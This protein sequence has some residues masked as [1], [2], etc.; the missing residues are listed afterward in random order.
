MCAFYES[1]VSN[2]TWHDVYI[3]ELKQVTF[4]TTRTAWVKLGLW[5]VKNVNFTSGRRPCCQKRHLLKLT[6]VLFFSLFSHNAI[7]SNVAPFSLY[8]VS[9]KVCMQVWTSRNSKFPSLGVV[10]CHREVWVLHGQKRWPC[11]TAC[12]TG[13]NNIML[14]Y[15]LQLTTLNNIIHLEWGATML[16]NIVNIREQ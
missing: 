9:L 5:L 7:T 14:T 11:C 6:I 13:C 16:N 8:L 1:L 10:S 2:L 3:S 4:L 15:F 12:T